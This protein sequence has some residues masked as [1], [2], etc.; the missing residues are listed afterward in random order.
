MSY[1]RIYPAKNNTVFKKNTGS[2]Q[3]RNGNINTGQNAI[4]ELMDGNGESFLVFDFDIDSL[5][6]T[7]ESHDFTCKLKLWDAGQV[8]EPAIKPKD[9]DL[10]FFEESFVEGNGFDF[11]GNDVLEQPSNFNL[12]NETDDWD[13]VIKGGGLDGLFPATTV[14]PANGDILVDVTQ[15]V[16]TALTDTT[17]PK[18]ALTIS[19]HE[20]DDATFTK[21][22]HSRHTR[23]IFQP[24]LEFEIDDQIV[25]SRHNTVAT[26][27]NR[28][29]LLSDSG[30]NFVG[31]TVS[32][33]IQ[34]GSGTSI[35]SPS[36]NNPSPGVYYIEY[37]PPIS[38]VGEKLFD[39]WSVD[40][41]TISKQ[42]INVTSPNIVFAND[43][44]FNGLFFHPATAYSHAAIRRNDKVRFNIISEI[45]GSGSVLIDNFE[46][47]V[48]ATNNFEMIP[49]TPAS[50]YNNQ[51]FF[52]IDTTFFYPELN[53][54]VFV[55]FKGKDF[56][57]TSDLTE[58]FRLVED[59]ATH[60]QGR[61]ASPYN[62]RN[63]TFKK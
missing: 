18:F 36:V 50:I 15:F 55:R 54:E 11:T 14:D 29:Y 9:V 43:D 62:N 1:I 30:E 17:N 31:T 5:R 51:S 8:F 13:G 4:M 38:R 19:N 41:T 45:R 32:A 23:T 6:T 46:Y 22:I 37:T 25:D 47:R 57:R 53:Y 12:R 49:W 35:A 27:N 26:K 63:F 16:D 44:K 24:F 2:Q 39:V 7:L 58:K 20:D 59:A 42:I 28:I 3:Q 33:E 34:D 48:V 52:T 60:L 21:F 40:G 10:I 61:N 56:T